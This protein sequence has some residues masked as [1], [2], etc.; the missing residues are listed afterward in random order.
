MS[1]S[2]NREPSAAPEIPSLAKAFPVWLKIGL[3]SFG[4]PAGQIAL[5]HRLLVDEHKWIDED[6]F[7][8]GLNF[9]MLLPGPEAQQLATYVG[10]RMHGILGGLIAGMLFVLPG[11]FVIF[12]LSF[13]YMEFNDLQI[14]SGI[15]FGI[16]AAV[17]AIVLDAL[18]RISKKALRTRPSYV[19]A[20]AAFVSVF[21]FG[22]AFPWIVAAAALFGFLSKRAGKSWFVAGGHGKASHASDTKPMPI[23]S[24]LI[25]GGVCL[26]LW[27]L[28]LGLLNFAATDSIFTEQAIFF[29]KMSVVTFGGAYAVLTYVAQQA[30]ETLGWLNAG[31]MVDGLGLAE[32][33][34]GPLVL[35]LQFVGYLGAARD[36]TSMSPLLAGLVGS[37]IVLWATFLPCFA[38]IFLG[39]P[40]IDRL[41]RAPALSSALSAVTAAVVGV[42]LNLS[43]WFAIHVLFREVA[44]V[45]YGAFQFL[46]PS[47]ISV[48]WVALLLAGLSV[49]ALLKFRVSVLWLLAAMGLA[50]L[51]LSFSGLPV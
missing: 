19:V 41:S 42:V 44:A 35:V 50:G 37:L 32:T 2:K 34:P 45:E 3:L 13:V 47:V 8:Q 39:G 11:A 51:A 4:G 17:I 40:F 49:I 1:D 20:A 25:A 36:A 14:M 29:S 23:R 12:A 5:M 21:F 18:I 46:L 48:D 33:T 22:V 28:P 15:F 9:C 38:W 24:G 30:V 6:R 26:A 7:L 43:L 31:E 27:L 10:W 16:K